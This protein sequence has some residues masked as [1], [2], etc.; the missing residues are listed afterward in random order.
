MKKFLM[1]LLCLIAFWLGQCSAK[2]FAPLC[3][4]EYGLKLNEVVLC[5]QVGEL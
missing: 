2:K 3:A 4:D 5:K 1:F